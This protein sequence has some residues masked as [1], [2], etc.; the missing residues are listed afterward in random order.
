MTVEQIR[1]VGTVK[2]TVFDLPHAMSLSPSDCNVLVVSSRTLFFVQLF[3]TG[4]MDF[5]SRYASTFLEGN[6]YILAE[7][8]AELDDIND[9]INNYELEV[10]PVTCDLIAAIEALTA[11]TISAGS[12]CCT[13]YGEVPPPQAPNTGNPDIDPP[14]DD[15]T[16]WASYYTYKC[17]AANKIA[18]D[19][20]ATCQNLSTL[21]AVVLVIG[22]VALAAFLFTSLLS[23]IIV[24]LMALGFA[25]GTAAAIIIQA[26]SFIIAGG[27]GLM[28]Y[29]SLMATE[30]ESQKTDLVCLLFEATSVD[31]ATS[32]IL[33][34]TADIAANLIYDPGDDGELFQE[35]LASL[36]EA[37]FNVALINTL[38]ELNS[39]ADS[40]VGTVDCSACAGSAGCIEWTF[41]YSNEGWTFEDRSDPGSFASV[42]Y[43][44]GQ[45]SLEVLLNVESAP[46]VCAEGMNFSPPITISVAA[47]GSIDVFHSGSSDPPNLTGVM[48]RAIYDDDSEYEANYSVLGPGMVSLDFSVAGVLKE[49]QVRNKRCT[50]GSAMGTTSTIDILT[51]VVNCS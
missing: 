49:V 51:V 40:Y 33:G 6:K 24:G 7:D 21:S 25:A 37:L 32:E 3:G 14:P 13:P 48:V 39:D 17:K 1:D 5:V 50:S 29:F 31:I 18:D 12:G 16:T 23:G 9:L 45:E 11:A 4:E 47:T 28:Q 41:Q 43:D 42:V 15:W 26:I 34:F 20:I 35:G 22:L 30:M 38:F 36:T 46:N 8:S 19:W 27:A 10:Q 44:S 2:G